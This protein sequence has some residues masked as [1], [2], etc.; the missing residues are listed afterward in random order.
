MKW[1]YR[2]WATWLAE[3]Y[4]DKATYFYTASMIIDGFLIGIILIFFLTYGQTVACICDCPNATAYNIIP[5]A[6][7]LTNMSN[8]VMR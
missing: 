2:G 8:I 5:N 3:K 4:P 7:G 6:T 1:K